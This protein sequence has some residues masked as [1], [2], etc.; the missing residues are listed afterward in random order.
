MNEIFSHVECN[1]IPTRCS[2]Q[3]L[4]LSHFKTNQDFLNAFKHN[5]KDHYFRKGNK[6]E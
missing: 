6:K 2:Y 5:L 3:R 4:K 1:G